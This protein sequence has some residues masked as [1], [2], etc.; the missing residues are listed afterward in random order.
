MGSGGFRAVPSSG[1]SRPPPIGYFGWALR[2]ALREYVR[3]FLLVASICALLA[4]AGLLI[5]ARSLVAAAGLVAA[6]GVA[7]LVTSVIGVYRFYGRPAIRYY[8][9]IVAVAVLERV[10]LSVADLHVGTYRHTQ[11]LAE[12]LPRAQIH[13]VDCWDEE[14]SPPDAAL[15]EL[16]SAEPPPEGKP[17]VHLVRVK[18]GKVPLPD[19]SCDAVVL[20]IGIHEIDPP[21]RERL[22]V[23]AARLLR[24]EGR[25]VLFE[26]VRNLRNALVF[27]VVIRHWPGRDAWLSA[28]R[29]HFQRVEHVAVWPTVDLFMGSRR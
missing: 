8:R 3:G 17:S 26:H 28:L 18:N 4:G 12:L 21:V 7:L 6:L 15:R 24:P 1:S 27:G 11:A 19:A 13:S 25:V 2:V 22:F 10:P 16:R 9:R 14:L 5:D 29:R 20:G 23:E